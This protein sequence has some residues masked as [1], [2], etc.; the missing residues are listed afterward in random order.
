VF[1][2]P[3]LASSWNQMSTLLSPMWPGIL[4][5]V[6]ILNFFKIVLDLLGLTRVLGAW[7]YPRE[8]HV[9]KQI[10]DRVW[11]VVFIKLFHDISM[12]ISTC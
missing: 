12:N 11:V 5:I 8:A 6:S 4:R 7:C 2:W 10:V 3:N 1:C 9:I